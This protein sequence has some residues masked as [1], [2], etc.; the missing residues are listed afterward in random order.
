V[1]SWSHANH[2]VLLN[3][4]IYSR[5][6]WVFRLEGRIPY[7]FGRAVSESIP[8]LSNWLLHSI[9]RDSALHIEIVGIKGHS[10]ILLLRP[11]LSG[12]V[13]PIKRPHTYRLVSGP[14][15]E[16]VDPVLDLFWQAVQFLELDLTLWSVALLTN[17]STLERFKVLRSIVISRSSVGSEPLN[18]HIST[19]VSIRWIACQSF[20][21]RLNVPS[22]HRTSS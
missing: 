17:D 20:R 4:G 18:A 6:L 14:V 3:L 12:K 22:R 5:I 9:H 16:L 19:H 10:V 2:H 15:V 1:L 21:W 11:R 7:I 8:V 13:S